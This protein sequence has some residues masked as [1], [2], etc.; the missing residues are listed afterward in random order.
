MRSLC[1]VEGPLHPTYALPKSA[2]ENAPGAEPKNAALSSCQ[3]S[4]DFANPFAS[5]WADSAQ[6]ERSY[7]CGLSGGADL[8]FSPG[9]FCTSCPS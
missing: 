7:F 4:F 1:A 9:A 8:S 6:D 3:G 2:G 5:E